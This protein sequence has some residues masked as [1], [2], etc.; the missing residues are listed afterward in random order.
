MTECPFRGGLCIEGC[1]A[2]ESGQSN[3]AKDPHYIELSMAATLFAGTD[4]G[5]QSLAQMRAL[6]KKH[7]IR[8]AAL[9]KKPCRRVET[10]K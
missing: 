6:E 7:T 2:R 3:A 10:G 1:N 5:V 8:A 9:G 4:A